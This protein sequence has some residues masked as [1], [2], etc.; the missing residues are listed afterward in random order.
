MFPEAATELKR[1]APRIRP[2]AR[3]VADIDGGRV[4]LY[5]FGPK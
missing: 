3:A 2:A 4:F 5:H 1:K